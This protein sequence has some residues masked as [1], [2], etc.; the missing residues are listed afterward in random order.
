M[1][2]NSTREIIA[3]IVAFCAVV[4]AFYAADSIIRQITT[5]QISFLTAMLFIGGTSTVVA[6]WLIRSPLI[7]SPNISLVSL[8]VFT[9]YLGGGLPY[10]HVLSVLFL[11]GFIVFLFGITGAGNGLL[12]C[13]PQSLYPGFVA[14][15]GLLLFSTG[16]RE[17]G[18]VTAH[19]VTIM[20]VGDFTTRGPVI[21]IV[22]VL[23][24][25][26]TWSRGLKI[27][28]LWAG[29][30]A[31][32][33]GTI[34]GVVPSIDVSLLT[35]PQI[36]S[37]PILESTRL[38]LLCNTR[39]MPSI[40]LIIII[41]TLTIY[42]AIMAFTDQT[43]T[44]R[45]KSQQR[46]WL[47]TGIAG[48]ISP[49][50]GVPGPL[51]S[52]EGFIAKLAGGK[53]GLAGIITGVLLLLCLFIPIPA[54]LIGSGYHIGNNLWLHP[55]TASLLISGGLLSMVALG[56]VDWENVEIAVPTAVI[57]VLTPLAF[58]IVTGVGSGIVIYTIIR[59]A[60]G[61]V[62]PVRPLLVFL[63]PLVLLRYIL[64]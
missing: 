55:I 16:L 37:Y 42:L 28:L 61:E 21:T 30:A 26:I 46:I 62:S 36:Q 11:T 64:L 35:I 48:V 29:L 12:K 56:K 63:I 25:V 50:A 17:A 39:F 31:V 34:L 57:V 45:E 9:M 43:D 10:T 18:I 52:V 40:T 33:M 59:L 47:V 24:F 27:P 2:N 7:F 22:A 15:T 53:S 32:L 38:F 20:T 4:P 5:T 44:L 6:S 51:L 41:E 54:Q 14:G 49:F 13:I 1:S 3:G 58:S 60:K 8:M 19:P 23:I